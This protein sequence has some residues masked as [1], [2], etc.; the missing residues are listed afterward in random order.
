MNS[1][2][3]IENWVEGKFIS[4]IVPIYWGDSFE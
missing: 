1:G 3:F 4:A 2:I